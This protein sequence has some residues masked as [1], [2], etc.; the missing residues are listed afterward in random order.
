[1]S[2]RNSF[3]LACLFTITGTSYSATSEPAV[4]RI[5]V[6]GPFSGGSAPMGESM[7]NGIRLAVDE[8]NSIGGI[9]GRKIELVERDDEANNELGAR[10]ANDLITQKVVATIGIVNTGVGLASIDMYQKARIPLMI[11][12]STGTS[13]TKKYAPPAAQENYIFRVAPTLDLE[14]RKIV[15]DLQKRGVTNVAMLADTTAYGEAGLN[16]FRQYAGVAG[17]TLSAVERFKIGD[18]NLGPQIAAVKASGANALVAW[19]IGPELAAIARAK[20]DA[21]WKVPMLGSW[22]FSMGNF[23]EMAGKTGDGV[24]MPQTFIQDAGSISKNS[25]LLAY[26]RVFKTDRIPSPM[27]AAQGY[28]GMHLLAMAMRQANSTEGQKIKAA[29]ETLKS[30]YQGAITSYE[31]PFSSADHDAITQNMLLM[32]KVSSG[33]VDYAYTEDQNRSGLLR[34]KT[35]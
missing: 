33:R 24:L 6:S 2:F 7:R 8:L 28:D 27:S 16:A 30:R 13:L 10:V 18:Q 26:R 15:S 11:A 23:I 5:G 14:A 3:L 25:F 29:L 34:M 35:N 20:M 9:N 32:G 12:V 1:M 19:G 17:I 22:T 21:G 31:K 4:V